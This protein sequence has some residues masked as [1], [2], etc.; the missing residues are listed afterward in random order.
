[1]AT[2]PPP[3]P[4][5]SIPIQLPAL[6]FDYG[7][8]TDQTGARKKLTCEEVFGGDLCKQLKELQ[9]NA[10]EL[11]KE[12]DVYVTE[13]NKI[14]EQNEK[15]I[16][17]LK[18]QLEERPT[19]DIV[20]QL[21]RKIELLEAQNKRLTDETSRL[22][23]A[24]NGVV[25]ST[26]TYMGS[27]REGLTNAKKRKLGSVAIDQSGAGQ[28]EVQDE[29]GVVGDGMEDVIEKEDYNALCD[30]INDEI[31]AFRATW[32]EVTQNDKARFIRAAGD[33]QDNLS[34]FVRP[35]AMSDADFQ[36]LVQYL[37]E[38]LS[39]VKTDRGIPVRR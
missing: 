6:T 39:K 11:T 20:K 35:R 32:P 37:E 25:T 5:A 15:Q 9:E 23:G 34:N 12:I 28:G 31:R 10:K 8:I 1:M 24:V 14:I 7:D 17:T 38:Q 29:Q 21:D 3:V 27:I 16:E 26:N 30:K 13:N 18:K 22:K 2:V 33:L 19:P 36:Y 4:Q